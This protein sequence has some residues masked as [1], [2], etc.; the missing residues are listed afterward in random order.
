[1]KQRKP[2]QRTAFKRKTPMRRKEPSYSQETKPLAYEQGDI[3]EIRAAAIPRVKSSRG[4]IA[5]I[6]GE[7]RAVPKPQPKRNRA[8]LDMAELRPCLLLIPNICLND[9]FSAV[10]AHSNLSI[11]GKAKSRK[12]DDQF[13]TWSCAACHRWLDQGPASAAE[14]EAAFMAAHLRQVLEWRRIATDSTEPE[15]FRKA[16]LWA[17]NTLNATPIGA[18]E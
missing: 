17:L 5:R 3:A 4:V 8:L 6:D 13:S 9:Y 16:A 1:M 2:L 12:A 14:K 10:A 11:H 7:V 15:R 18:L